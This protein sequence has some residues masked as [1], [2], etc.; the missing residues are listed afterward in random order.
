MNPRIILLISALIPEGFLFGQNLVPN[1][2]FEDHTSCPNDYGQVERSSGWLPSTNN[3]DPEFHTEFLHSCGTPT[4]GTPSNTWGY[5]LPMTGD[6]YMATVSMAPSVMLNYREN[7][8][9]Q[10]IEPLEVGKHYSFQVS[11]SLADNSRYA[12]NNFGAKL[13]TSANFPINNICLLAWPSVVTNTDDWTTISVEFVADSAYTHIAIGNFMTDANTT[14]ITACASCP[15]TL[16]GYYVD[17]VCLVNTSGSPFYN[18][19]VPVVVQAIEEVSAWQLSIYP[20]T[21]SSSSE[22]VN[23]QL[24]WNNATS[25]RI[26]DT[27]GRV[28]RSLSSVYTPVTIPIANLAA[29]SYTVVAT[30]PNGLRI[31]GQFAVLR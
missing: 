9:T 15:F 23:I 31:N 7:I 30:N 21:A 5:Q 16:H 25:I 20:S 12:S 18:C 27:N 11:I 24:P 26:F 10:L 17:D 6:G 2:S 1:Y 14:S 28:V 22:E 19:S 13:S 4:F 8:Y 29:G 3:N